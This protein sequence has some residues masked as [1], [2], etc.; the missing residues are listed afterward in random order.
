MMMRNESLSIL[1]NFDGFCT[2]N[3]DGNE[4]VPFF[5]ELC[6]LFNFD[7]ARIKEYFQPVNRLF[8]LP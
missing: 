6:H 2:G 8:K 4:F 5:H 1:P 3:Q 7:Y